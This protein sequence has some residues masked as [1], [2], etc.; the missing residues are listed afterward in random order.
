MLLGDLRGVL[1][2]LG[3]RVSEVGPRG[4]FGVRGSGS[5]GLGLRV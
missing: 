5:R 2:G 3:C 1:G 4:S